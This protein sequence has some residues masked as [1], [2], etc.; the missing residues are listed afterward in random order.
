MLVHNMQRKESIVLVFDPK[1]KIEKNGLK[2][3]EY[4][5][6]DFQGCLVGNVRAIK[7]LL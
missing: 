5:T 6:E 7:Q 3:K 1:N 4:T 2:I